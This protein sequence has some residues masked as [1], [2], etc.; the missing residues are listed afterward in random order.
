MRGH[1]TRNQGCGEQVDNAAGNTGTKRIV[2]V[3]FCIIAFLFVGLVAQRMLS[4]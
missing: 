1:E 2:L 4:A 3:T